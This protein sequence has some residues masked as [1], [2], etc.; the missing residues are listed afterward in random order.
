MTFFAVLSFEK[1][2][3]SN[4]LLIELFEWQNLLM[5]THGQMKN[6]Y[7][8]KEMELI[9]LFFSSIRLCT[10]AIFHIC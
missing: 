1:L 2:R 8:V 3:I 5:D 6:G 7:K 9:F 4:L 10:F